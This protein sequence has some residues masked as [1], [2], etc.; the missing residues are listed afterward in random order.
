LARCKNARRRRAFIVFE[1]ESGVSLSP[2]VRR[3]WAPKGKTPVLRTHFNWKRLSMA[4]ALVYAHDGAARVLFSSR[5]GSYDAGSLI[6]FLGEL[7]V[8][9]D[10]E[11]V[12][13]ISD[14][15]T[16]HRREQCALSSRDS[17]TGWSSS[18]S[19][20]TRPS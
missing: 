17:A 14:G 5:P 19:P 18:A 4:A 8:E 6:E 20:P 7:H 10:G 13:L 11:K 9:L 15:L 16:S 1:D 3:T 2:S 12:T